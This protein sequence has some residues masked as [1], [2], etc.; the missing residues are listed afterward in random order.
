MKI[1]KQQ[2]KQI[3]KEELRDYYGGKSHSQ[4]KRDAAQPRRPDFQVQPAGMTKEDEAFLINNDFNDPPMGLTDAQEKAY[5]DALREKPKKHD[6]IY[7]LYKRVADENEME[8][9]RGL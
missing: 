1:T 5:V 7:E 6:E 4:S 3:I 8:Y 9:E 2:L